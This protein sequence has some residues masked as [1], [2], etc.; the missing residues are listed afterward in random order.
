MGKAK[1]SVRAAI[2]STRQEPQDSWMKDLQLQTAAVAS[3][4]ALLKCA[5]LSASDK[6]DVLRRWYYDTAELA[7]G[8]RRHASAPGRR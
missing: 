7:R 1:L 3:P 4:G 8:G 2:A 5:A 6:L